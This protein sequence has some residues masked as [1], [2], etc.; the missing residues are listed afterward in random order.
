MPLKIDALTKQGLFFPVVCFIYIVCFSY[1]TLAEQP[2]RDKG[3][4]SKHCA[5]G[6][7]VESIGWLL[8][9]VRYTLALKDREQNTYTRATPSMGL[10][11]NTLHTNI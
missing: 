10:K 3:L 7:K 11:I 8:F 5:T 9:R 6:E 2:Y 1:Q 4:W